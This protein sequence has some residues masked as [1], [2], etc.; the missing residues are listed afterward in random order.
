[1]DESKESKNRVIDLDKIRQDLTPPNR[2]R[3]RAL[4]RTQQR[5]QGTKNRQ[6]EKEMNSTVPRSEILGWVNAVTAMVKGLESRLSRTELMVAALF[7]V[8]ADKNIINDGEIDDA[9]QFERQR[10]VVYMEIQ[11]PSGDYEDKLEKIK[12]W[13]IGIDATTL[14][15]Q[16]ESD[17]KLTDEQRKALL[18]KCEL[19]QPKK[20]SKE[21]DKK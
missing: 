10:S 18:K 21:T 15:S 9:I 20:P 6:L 14:V 7:K 11:K 2:Q 1:M 17:K 13:D 8:L 5:D 12:K 4:K 19:L 3:R 16:I